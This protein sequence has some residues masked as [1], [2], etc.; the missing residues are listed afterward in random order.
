MGLLVFRDTPD[1]RVYV[2]RIDSDSVAGATFQ[3]DRNY[4]DEAQQ[5]DQLGIS[6]RL[7]LDLAPYDSGEAA[8][9]FSALLPDGEVMSELVRMYQVSRNDYLALLEQLGCESVGALTFMSERLNARE[10]VAQYEPLDKWTAESLVTTPVRTTAQIVSELRMSLPGAQSKV[11]WFLPEDLTASSAALNDWL[12]PKGTAPSTHIIK[13]SRKG[14]EDLVFN[15]LVC[16]LLA[17]ACGIDAAEATLIEGLS[18]ALAIK[19]YDRIWVGDQDD[20]RVLRLHQE[21]ACQALGL[22]AHFKYQPDSIEQSYIKMIGALLDDTVEDP[23]A[24]KREFAKRLVFNYLIGNAEAHLRSISLLYNERWTGR[25]LA[26]LYGAICVPLTG[27]SSKM[28]FDI[29]KHRYLQDVDEQDLMAIPQELDIPV[30]VFEK[31]IQEVVEGLESFDPEGLSAD[32]T[33]MVDR[34]LSNAEPRVAVAKRSMS[35]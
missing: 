12:V 24:G 30:P 35:L 4:L 29:G 11:A 14:E 3:Y 27:Y 19:R 5:A 21:D 28:A 9:F 20:R 1:G 17:T 25:R 8:L 22:P 23:Y 6:E 13:L 31:V 10:Y 16:S 18:G 34:I 15:E 7:P 26:P 2:G 32:A 33:A